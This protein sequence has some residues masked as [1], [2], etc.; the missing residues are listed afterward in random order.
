MEETKDVN[1]F[2]KYGYIFLGIS[3][4]LFVA[5]SAMY[6]SGKDLTVI[7]IF[8]IITMLLGCFCIFESKYLAKEKEKQQKERQI[9]VEIEKNKKAKEKTYHVLDSL[10]FEYA[11]FGTDCKIWISNGNLYDVDFIKLIYF[12]KE[13]PEMGNSEIIKKSKCFTIIPIKYIAFFYKEGDVQYTTKV[14]GGGGGGSSLTGALVGGLIAGGTGAIIG[15][16]KKNEEIKS[17]VVT[18]HNDRKVV[19]RY[20]ENGSVKILSREDKEFEIY[21]YLLKKI[22]EKDLLTIQ[23]NQT[24]ISNNAVSAEEN[25]SDDIGSKNQDISERLQKLQNLYDSKLITESEYTSKRQ[26]ILDSL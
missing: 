23:M 10:S 22:P 18:A 12:C 3:L 26:D 19:I 20:N 9:E 17:T 5:I 25:L 6:R 13:N 21:D 16:R 8:L 14:S 1:F 4:T 2:K 7:S 11:T 24:L 15:S